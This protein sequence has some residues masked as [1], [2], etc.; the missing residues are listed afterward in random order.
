MSITILDLEIYKFKNC[1]LI[2]TLILRDAV[3][4]LDPKAAE[5]LG[6][7]CCTFELDF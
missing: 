5:S 1:A 2:L 3:P 4:N 6:D 7:G